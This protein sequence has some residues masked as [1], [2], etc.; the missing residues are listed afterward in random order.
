M[1]A[2]IKR[3]RAWL[4]ELRRIVHLGWGRLETHRMRL[5]ALRDDMK[6]LERLVRERTDIA[7]DVGVDGMNTVIVVG[8]YKGADY[9][10][11]YRL[12]ADDLDF[13]IGKLREM[14][15]HGALRRLDCPPQYRAVFEHELGR[16]P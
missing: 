11:T 13:L 4:F 8:R 12:R 10:Q 2:T 14:E 3:A 5:D 7:V 9:V 6:T 1:I 16:R 15:R